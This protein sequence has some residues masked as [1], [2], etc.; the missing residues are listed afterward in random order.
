MIVD[1]YAHHPSEVNATLTAARNGW[2]KRLIA[3]FQPHLYSRTK[4]FYIDFAKALSQADLV[5]ITEIYPAREKPINNVT[6]KL[7]T[8]Q[9]A[10][11]NCSNFIETKLEK[12][13]ET[14]NKIKNT[15]DLIIFMGAGNINSKIEETI[16]LIK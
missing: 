12:I 16:E 14:I 15:N 9:L 8:K 6:S 2:R 4:D 1:D 3:V 5:I 7:I 13:P 10:K 11:I